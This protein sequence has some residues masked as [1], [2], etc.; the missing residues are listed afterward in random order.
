MK[1]LSAK[2]K[3]VQTEFVK[4]LGYEAIAYSAVTKDIRKDVILKNEPEVEDRA[5]DQGF[6]ITGNAVLE[7]FEMILFSSIRQIAKITVIP[8]TTAFRGLMELL[9]FLLKR[10]R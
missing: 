1:G 10:L 4:V 5:E 9:H 6:S 8:P 2:A 7:A 3:D